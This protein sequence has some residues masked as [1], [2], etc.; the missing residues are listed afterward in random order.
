MDYHIYYYYYCCCYDY[1]SAILESVAMPS[2]V[3]SSLI[4]D[5]RRRLAATPIK[6]RA[7]IEVTCFTKEGIEA[8]KVH[9]EIFVHDI[10]V[11]HSRCMARKCFTLV[12]LEFGMFPHLLS[13]FVC[14]LRFRVHCLKGKKHRLARNKQSP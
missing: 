11:T 2:A 8:I 14:I 9:L 1:N 12:I 7:D 3:R 6:F 5:I 13:C 4:K 10:I